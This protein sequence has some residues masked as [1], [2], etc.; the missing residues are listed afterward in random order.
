MEELTGQKLYDFYERISL[1]LRSVECHARVEYEGSGAAGRP[2]ITIR[3]PP[4]YIPVHLD[5][6]QLLELLLGTIEWA[7]DWS[8]RL[9]KSRNELVEKL[10]EKCSE[11]GKDN[12]PDGMAIPETI[13][14]LK[15]LRAKGEG[16]SDGEMV[17]V[18]YRGPDGDRIMAG[19]LTPEDA[20]SYMRGLDQPPDWILDHVWIVPM[21][22]AR[23][24]ERETGGSSDE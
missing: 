4:L 22:Q 3:I 9:Y 21:S 16:A 13:E 15:G 2:R 24:L 18:E 20:E 11:C 7:D 8:K 6:Y 10:S 19:P 5:D 1:P 14:Y 17:Q 12:V 23:D